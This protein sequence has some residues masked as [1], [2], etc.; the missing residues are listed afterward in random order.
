MSVRHHPTGRPDMRVLIQV[1]AALLS[2]AFVMLAV[3]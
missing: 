1:V 3:I 2:S